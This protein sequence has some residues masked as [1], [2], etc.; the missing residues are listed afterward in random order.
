ML[1]IIGLFLITM[2]ILLLFNFL[3]DFII[4]SANKYTL[5]SDVIIEYCDGHV[6]T[7]KNITIYSQYFPYDLKNNPF[8]IS[9]YKES[10]PVFYYNEGKEINVCK[11]LPLNVICLN[12]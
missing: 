12:P 1:R 11:V 3:I 2:S 9:T 4:P 6:D 8:Q 5:K 10:N 7:L